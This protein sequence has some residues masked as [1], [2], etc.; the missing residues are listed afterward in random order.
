MEEICNQLEGVVVDS[1]DAFKKEN[2]I[3]PQQLIFFRDGVGDS[4]KKSLMETEIG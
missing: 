2:G 3:F 1:L 4:Q